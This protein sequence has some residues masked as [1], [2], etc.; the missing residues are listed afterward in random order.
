MTRQP[1][2]RES[3]RRCISTATVSRCLEDSPVTRRQLLSSPSPGCQS[4]EVRAG[5]RTQHSKHRPAD[6]VP[7]PLVI[8]YEVA[9]RLRQLVT[10]PLTLES[11]RCLALA[12]RCSSTGGLDRIGGRAQLVRVNG[13]TAPAWPAAY[14]AFRAAPRRSLAAP[15]AWP[16]AARASI[17]L[18]SPRTQA[19]ACSIA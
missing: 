18:T 11:P 5:V 17:I 1:C 9:N 13:A 6:V 8:Q 2:H 16:P 14:A 19:R 12:F 4:V 15:I 10:L 7:Q 3:Q